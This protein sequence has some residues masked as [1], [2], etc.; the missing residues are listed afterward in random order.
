M[1]KHSVVYAINTFMG[2][3]LLATVPLGTATITSYSLEEN[4]TVT[5][6]PEQPIQAAIVEAL[7]GSVIC[8]TEGT[9]EENVVIEKPLT[10]QGAGPRKTSILGAWGPNPVIEIRGDVEVTLKGISFRY[11]NPGL[12][13]SDRARVT[14]QS[15]T[16]ANNGIGLVLQGLAQSILRNSTVNRNL[17]SGLMLFDS[18]RAIVQNSRISSNGS[19]LSAGISA[20][21]SLQGSEIINNRGDGLALRGSVQVIVED[22]LIKGNGRHER[23]QHPGVESYKICNGIEVADEAH[24]ELRRTMI[25]ENTDWG[26]AVTL[27]KC[28][29]DEDHF[30]GRVLWEGRGNEIHDNGQGDVC[31]P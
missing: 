8:L 24:V 9:W 6:T 3:I 25:V 26:I 16:I 23:C 10:L 22:S 29:Y 11:G 7:P 1:M 12:R 20:R 19:G 17:H 28:G 14:V 5:L 4:C 18:A 15:S 27:R 21:I 30:T 13:V 2:L 31:L